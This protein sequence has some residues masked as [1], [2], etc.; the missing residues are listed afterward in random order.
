MLDVR[1]CVLPLLWTKHAV[2]MYPGSTYSTEIKKL[3][4]SAVK[5]NKLNSVLG[6]MSNIKVVII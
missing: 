2:N 5:E 6:V 1:L 3:P 4:H